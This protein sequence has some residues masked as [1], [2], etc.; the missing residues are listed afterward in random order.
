MRSALE[1]FFHLCGKRAR[2]R[3]AS[4]RASEKDQG[5][6][7]PRLRTKLAAARIGR[8]R[9]TP[10]RGRSAMATEP[11]TAD[12]AAIAAALADEEPPSKMQEVL[13]FE[14]RIDGDDFVGC[15]L[16]HYWAGDNAWYFARILTFD[17]EK[18][19]HI[20]LYDDGEVHEVNLLDSNELYMIGRGCYV[21]KMPG[22]SPWPCMEWECCQALEDA[23]TMRMW[24]RRTPSKMFIIYFGND[25]RVPRRCLHFNTNRLRE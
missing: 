4:T 5:V 8:A 22:H 1:P 23:G 14:K 3:S 7:S 20:V 25:L 11:D 16:R 12:D 24:N 10:A 9:R 13:D 15:R 19:L 21:V 6:L 2:R 17:H 18:R